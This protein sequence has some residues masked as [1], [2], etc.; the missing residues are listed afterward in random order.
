[1]EVRI[2]INQS[3]RELSFETDATADELSALIQAEPTGLVEIADSKGRKFLVNREAITYVELG[4]DTSRKVG[5][6]N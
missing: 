2:G 5:F 4:S 6:V 1:M 3:A